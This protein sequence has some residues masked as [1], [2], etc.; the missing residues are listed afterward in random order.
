MRTI[1][2]IAGKELSDLFGSR[3]KGIRMLLIAGILPVFLLIGLRI[4]AA[5]PDYDAARLPASLLVAFV[6]VGVL[7]LI[8][9]MGIASTSF[10]S[11]VESGTIV[12]LLASPARTSAIFGGKLVAAMS[13][14]VALAWLAQG[15]LYLLFSPVVGRP[16]AVPSGLT[17]LV[18][19]SV[20][21][22]M[23]PL[24]ALTMVVA[25]RARRVRTA[26]TNSN[27][28]SLAVLVIA[29]LVTLRRPMLT[30]ALVAAVGVAWTIG[31]AVLLAVGIRM[32]DREELL[33]RPD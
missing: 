28:A 21:V 32:W 10:A 6:Q 12:P 20:P 2:L 5:R 25:S 15:L 30:L 16:W 22:S 18:A 1:R 23:F 19:A 17:L 4:Q 7:P 29:T 27:L 8:V 14:G 13:T 11:E 9:S 3:A 24:V 33:S 26:Q 31:G